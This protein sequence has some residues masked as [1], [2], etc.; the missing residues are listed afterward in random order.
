ME[1]ILM[2]M[3]DDYL[4]I[5]DE[6][7]EVWKIKDDLAADYALDKIRESTAEYR[8]FEM[9]AKN[10]IKQ[11]EDA[12]KK[13]KTKYEDEASFFE[14]KLRE[15]FETVKT[16]ETKTLE[17]YKLPSGQLKK[18]KESAIFKYD[19]KKL[20]EIAE[21][22]ENMMDYVKIKRDFDWAEFK[23]NLEIKG[24]TIV[25]KTTGEIV[26]IEGL[27]IEIKPEEFKVEV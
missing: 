14:G 5:K 21:Q 8:R 4:D 11:I 19:K 17:K 18:K 27:E 23:K 9:V 26:D 24:N 16:E 20:V 2:K 15:Y 12:L 7:K 3:I 1:N 6:T 13:Q 10:K 25:N 22:Y